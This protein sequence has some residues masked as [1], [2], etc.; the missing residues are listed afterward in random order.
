MAAVLTY[1]LPL[2]FC[3]HISAYLKLIAK[4][5]RPFFSVTSA[6]SCA[7]FARCMFIES[8]PPEIQESRIYTL[9]YP[10]IPHSPGSY[11]PDIPQHIPLT[12]PSIYPWHTPAYTPDIPLTYPRLPLR[13]GNR[14]RGRI[15]AVLTA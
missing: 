13:R 8:I 4:S 15:A 1:D 10:F 6:A 3:A 5:S 7:R 9:L 14:S 11:T 2:W 12:Y